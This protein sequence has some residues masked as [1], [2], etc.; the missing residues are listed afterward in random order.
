MSRPAGPPRPLLDVST[1][2]GALEAYETQLEYLEQRVRQVVEDTWSRLPQDP[3]ERGAYL[4]DVLGDV[5]GVLGD[6][7]ALLGGQYVVN[8]RVAHGE[9]PGDV[10]YSERHAPETVTRQREEVLAELDE[11]GAS[12]ALRLLSR[13]V[14]GTVMGRSRNTVVLS[15]A[16]AGSGWCRVPERGACWF[17][18]MLASRG[19][20]YRSRDTALGSRG[21]YHAH[22]RCVAAEVVGGHLP[23]RAQACVDYYQD[24]G[25]LDR[26][27]VVSGAFTRATGIP[28]TSLEEHD[29]ARL[30]RSRV[31]AGFVPDHLDP[32]VS[33]TQWPPP[34]EENIRVA[35]EGKAVTRTLRS[36]RTVTRYQG[37]HRSGRGYPGKAEFPPSWTEDDVAAAAVLTMADP[38]WTALSGDRRRYRRDVHGVIV[39]AAWYLTPSGEMVFSHCYPVAGDDVVYNPSPGA[40]TRDVSYRIDI[41]RGDG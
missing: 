6:Q 18:L 34:T 16:A 11:R 7:A 32:R 19:A 25:G 39:E 17:C 31:P 41:L 9:P 24:H 36:G 33:T 23:A 12:Q 1:P 2:E 35:W 27:D 4:E 21:R 14:A 40:P 37:G 8:N 30:G 28:S 29:D 5:V 13:R 20:V 15:A 3:G 22:C 10:V 26:Q 38:Q